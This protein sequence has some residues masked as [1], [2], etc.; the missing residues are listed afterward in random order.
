MNPLP[1]ID[2]ITLAICRS[3]Y[4]KFIIETPPQKYPTSVR[5]AIEDKC[6]KL[7]S[8]TQNDRGCLKLKEIAAFHEY[9]QLPYARPC[10]QFKP[11]QRNQ[12]K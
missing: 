2:C 3:Q 11:I 12:Y 10:N 8:Y 1:C 9:M 5:E 6:S 4:Y 7:K